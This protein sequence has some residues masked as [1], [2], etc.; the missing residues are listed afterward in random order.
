MRYKKPKKIFIYCVFFVI[1]YLVLMTSN[2]HKQYSLQVGQI[3]KTDIKATR[4][5]VNQKATDEK[6]KQIQDAVPEQYNKK[7]EVKSEIVNEINTIFSKINDIRKQSISDENKY[8]QMHTD[9]PISFDATQI[10]SLLKLQDNELKELQTILTTV[11]DEFYSGNRIEDNNEDDIKKAG[12]DLETKFNTLAIQDKYKSIAI[13]ISKNYI[14]PNF[15]FDEEKTTELRKEAIKNITPIVVKKDQ[16]IV[17]EGTPVT[18]EQLNLLADLGLIKDKSNRYWNIYISIG[19]L[20]AL[21][22]V[23]QDIYLKFY[24]TDIYSSNS[25]MLLIQILN[26]IALILARATYLVS[27]YMIPFAAV[28]ILMSLLLRWDVAVIIGLLNSVLICNIMGLEINI[29]FLTIIDIILV[30]MLIKKMNNRNEVIKASFYI[31]IINI[32]L[33]FFVGILGSSNIIFLIK[34]SLLS[35]VG[36]IVSAILALGALPFLETAFDIVTQGKLL[37]L[38]N[39]NNPLIKRLIIEA[40]GTYHHSVLVANLSEVAAEAI[41]ANSLL[42]RVGAYYHDIG[43]I[44]RPYFFKENQLGENPHNSLK[45]NIST[46]LILGHVKEGLELAKEAKLPSVI[47]DIIAQHHGTTLIKYFYITVKNNSSNPDDIKEEDFRYPGPKP[48]TKEAAIVMLADSVEAAVRSIVN[49]D[50]DKI[51]HMVEGI[52][53]DKMEDNQLIDSDL[54]FKDIELIKNSF[55]KILEGIYHQRIEYPT[56]KKAL[57]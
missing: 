25:K 54:T 15:F 46:M 28:P 55:V 31:A 44:K 16:I 11:I 21:I 42:A 57:E 33:C 32:I 6:R 43:K 36:A 1:S 18:D 26:I 2:V 10:N 37:E 22:I 40:S 56:E 29:L 41:G 12:E 4:D 50:R 3:A 35:G 5:V 7:S 53:K 8:N 20:L 48:Q 27:P 47:R 38:S 17:S 14:R 30:A 34:S 13:T 49:P 24:A 9:I 52:F 39:H 51:M 19:V 45:P 23:I